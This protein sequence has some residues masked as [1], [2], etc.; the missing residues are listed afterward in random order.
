LPIETQNS[1]IPNQQKQQL[2]SKLIVLYETLRNEQ[3]ETINPRH[4]SAKK[5]IINEDFKKKLEE[6][7]ENTYKVLKSLSCK[8]ESTGSFNI[9]IEQ[10]ISG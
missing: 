3:N 9:N 10:K 2:V 7:V 8:Q 5:L 4:V 6:I 1:E